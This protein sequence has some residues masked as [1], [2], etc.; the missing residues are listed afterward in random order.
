[1][2]MVLQLLWSPVQVPAAP[3]TIQLCARL[4]RKE[5]KDS[6]SAWASEP[7]KK[8]L[9]PDFNQ[10]SHGGCHHLQSELA[11][12]MFLSPLLSCNAVSKIKIM[13]RQ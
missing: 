13:L 2:H 8:L 3:L 5:V 1:M 11:D 12:E 10:A 7:R 4:L 9:A 6:T